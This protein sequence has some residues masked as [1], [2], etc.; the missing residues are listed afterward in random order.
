MGTSIDIAQW[1][2]EKLASYL[3]LS[4]T[5]GL[6]NTKTGYKSKGQCYFCC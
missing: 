6:I 1:T 2:S 5:V 3:S 4:S